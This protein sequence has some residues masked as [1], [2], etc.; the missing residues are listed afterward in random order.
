MCRGGGPGVPG[1]RQ[2]NT[3]RKI[4]LQVNSFK[5]RHFALPSMS[6]IFLCSPSPAG[7]I[8]LLFSKKLNKTTQNKCLFP[9]GSGLSTFVFLPRLNSQ[10]SRIRS[11]SEFFKDFSTLRLA[12]EFLS[13]NPKFFYYLF[14]VIEQMSQNVSSADFFHKDVKIHRQV[15]ISVCC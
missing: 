15:W 13:Q 10:R 9:H 3:C 6:I 14:A 12:Y 5:W 2:I 4:P 11:A 7:C 8:H 1:L